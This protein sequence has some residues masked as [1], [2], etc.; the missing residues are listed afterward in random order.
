MS[1][2]PTVDPSSE[3]RRPLDGHPS[4]ERR[5][6][7]WVRFLG[8]AV[9][10]LAVL[11]VGAALSGLSARKHLTQAEA[12]LRQGRADLIEGQTSA[13]RSSFADARARFVSAADTASGPWFRILGW[14]PI[15]GR[16]P[17]AVAAISEAGARVA[18]AGGTL[19]EA[20]S[21][22]PGGLAALAPEGGRVPIERFDALTSAVASARDE[23]AVATAMIERAPRTML[24]G[25]VGAARAQAEE[26]VRSLY[27]TLDT[28]SRLLEGLPL[29]LGSD[30]P[31][32]YFFG[33]QNPAELRGTGGVIGAYSILTID[34]GRFRFSAF[35]PVQSLPIPPLAS[36]PP[37]SEE[38]AANYDQFRGGGRFWLAIN[39]TP[40]FPSAAR[41][42][43]NAYEVAKGERL[44]GVLLA[45][46]FALQALLSVTGPVHVPGLDRTVDAGNVVAFTTNQ[47]YALYP[48]PST[49]KRLL[50]AVAEGVFEGLI[51][52]TG[53]GF[54]ALRTLARVASEGHILAYSGD[55]QMQA[56]LARTGAGGALSAGPGDLLAI[57]ENSS[58]GTK[59]DYYEDRAV[60]YEVDLWSG[61]SG[62]ATADIR[63]T[64]GAPTTGLPRYVIGPNPA[65]AAAGEGGQ[66]VSVYCGT[67]CRLEKA[68]RD[69]TQIGVWPGSELGHPFFEDYFR[70]P[71]GKTSDLQLTWYL[72]T[73][74]Q[75]G[76]TGGSYRLTFLNQTTI[77][78]T[79][80]RVEIHAPDGMRIVQTSPQMQVNGDSAVWE[81]VPNRRLELEI[82]FQPP[83]VVRLW[84]ALTG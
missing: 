58:A 47:A 9:A 56:G 23:V 81:G 18:D 28:G 55:P 63:L 31:R 6:R 42:I 46:P 70:T 52:E 60:R 73:A 51:A 75:G 66:L 30:G 53:T 80:L 68:V 71:S 25:P 15:V 24:L 44:D 29:F 32:R 1:D 82:R 12:A 14:V 2:P 4:K 20:I 41:E 48:D 59:V 7:G 78:P 43:I 83:L 36:V 38:Y 39:L 50:G 84:R 62:Q 22:L 40:D 16:T 8:A 26:Q 11:A 79:A 17:D 45:D 10:L 3:E 74:W 61:G 21:D 69:G 34:D 27:E 35:R 57:V 64:N 72:P 65:H 19:A 13:A 77:R 5:R 49:R 76:D 67:G 54:D 33:A 37:P